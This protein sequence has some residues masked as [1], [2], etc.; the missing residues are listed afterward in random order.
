[1]TSSNTN[2]TAAMCLS[3]Q[4]VAPFVERVKEYLPAQKPKRVQITYTH[5]TQQISIEFV[6]LWEKR[7]FSVYD[8]HSDATHPATNK[9]TVEQYAPKL[10]MA[11]MFSHDDPHNKRGYPTP[12]TL[13]D[14]DVLDLQLAQESPLALY[15]YGGNKHKTCDRLRLTLCTADNSLFQ[16]SLTGMEAQG[17]DRWE[18][19]WV[20]LITD[21]FFVDTKT[22]KIDYRIPMSADSWDV[23][24]RYH[25][26]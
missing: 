20:Y 3:R 9:R 24:I 1:M 5:P 25:G 23:K 14:R 4:M 17:D 7:S 26:Y 6:F 13:T 2:S 19:D 21:S 11:L 18:G 15:E 16:E 12:I 10:D 8:S 22:M